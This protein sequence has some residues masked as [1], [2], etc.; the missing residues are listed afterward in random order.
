MDCYK[1]VRKGLST[2]AVGKTVTPKLGMIFVFKELEDAQRFCSMYVYVYASDQYFYILRCSAPG[3]IKATRRL[4]GS[5]SRKHLEDFWANPQ[6]GLTGVPTGTWWAP[7]VTL[8]EDYGRSYALLYCELVLP[9]NGA[10]A[11]AYWSGQATDWMDLP[12]GTYFTDWVIPKEL[13][14]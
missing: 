12:K 13:C 11:E 10:S 8:L 4:G 14:S 9:E 3:L 5:W 7:S 1:V 6:V 2:D